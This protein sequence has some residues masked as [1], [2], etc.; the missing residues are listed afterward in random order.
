M[1]QHPIHGTWRLLSMESRTA[2]GQVTYPYGHE[3]TGFLTYADRSRMSIDIASSGRAPF[4]GGD[5]R[6]GTEAERAA[7][8]ATFL[9]YCGTFSV[10]PGRVI[11]HIEVC[12]FPNWVGVDQERS[13]KVEANR[14]SL[15]SGFFLFGGEMRSSHV[16]WE[17]V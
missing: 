11:H 14:L 4:D 10:V 7:A 6:G 5:L 8:A 3:A 15:S 13:Y 9:S 1:T 17:R 2:D 16:T 12:L